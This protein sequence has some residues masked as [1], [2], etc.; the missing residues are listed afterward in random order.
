MDFP[1]SLHLDYDPLNQPNIPTHHKLNATDVTVTL[2]D[3]FLLLIVVFLTLFFPFSS[4]QLLL[5]L[6]SFSF[7]LIL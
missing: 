4:V 5:G 2:G 7:L 6:L 3:S 1:V